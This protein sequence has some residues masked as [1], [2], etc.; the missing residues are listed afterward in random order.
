MKLAEALQIRADL[1]KRLLQIPNRLSRNATKQEGTTPA[2]DPVEILR[3]MDELTRQLEQITTNINLTNSTIVDSD[4]NTMTSLIAKRDY[5]RTKTGYL[6][7]F[8]SQASEI[9]FRRQSTDILILPTIDVAEYRKRLD[10]H[11]K[12][13]RELEL[14]IQSLNWTSELASNNE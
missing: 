1:Q 4:G 9:T 14:K 12:E 5:L 7:D 3:E 8:I 2:E 13:L 6:R 11:S 10:R